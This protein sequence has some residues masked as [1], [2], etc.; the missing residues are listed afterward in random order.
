[1][2]K[3]VVII[4]AGPAGLSCALEM[5]K[6]DDYEIIIVEKLNILGGIS[7]TENYKGNRIDLGGHRFFTKSDEVFKIWTS[8][9]PLQGYP[10]LDEI[11][12]GKHLEINYTH[13]GPDPQ[14]TD[15]VMLIRKRT[16]RIY[17]DNNFFDYPVSLNRNTISN[18]GV[19]KIF[20]IGISYFKTMINPI[21]EEKTLEDFFINRFGKEL[22]LTFFKDYTEKVWGIKCNEI[23]P[24]WGSQRVKGLSISSILKDIL[25]NTL[26]PK[27]KN[28]K[29]VETTLI[30]QF[31]YPKLGPGQMW[32]EI[33]KILINKGV[34]IIKNSSLIKTNL[35]NNKIISITIQ[36]NNTYQTTEIKTDYLIS[37]MPLKELINSMQLKYENINKIANDLHYRD[38]I[39]VGIMLNKLKLKNETKEKTINNI[40]PDNWIY[41]QDKSVK[42]GRLQIFNNWSPYMVSD[43]NKIWLGVEYFANEKDEFYR[44]ND[45]NIINT[46]VNELE[47]I[48]IINSSDFI[49]GTVIRV[50]KA[51]PVYDGGYEKIDII[52]DFINN[53]ENLYPI[54]RNGM[55]KYNNMDH[56]MLIGIETAKS[57]IT[58]KDKSK[59]WDINTEKDYHEEK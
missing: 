53:I 31:Y 8:I 21:R 35:N 4:G 6:Y 59:I 15:K 42:A 40:I 29:K 5:L 3:K 52:K 11:I 14:K 22:Y 1:M 55:H 18:L 27:Y 36:D 57:I 46:A 38:F 56:S 50:P 49:E 19:K 17:Y 41:L 51:Y 48:G 44:D 47:K 13:N 39:V 33:E 24:D 23:K 54:G 26:S 45:K 12:T 9:L 25:L 20:K 32:D 16:S 2:N 37:S 58:K 7:R 28:T 43:I 10:S 34:R 30:R